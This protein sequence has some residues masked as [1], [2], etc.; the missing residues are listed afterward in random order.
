M[1]IIENSDITNVIK[2][3]EQPVLYVC[4]T[5]TNEMESDCEETLQNIESTTENLIQ[6]VTKASHKLI[7]L[8]IE[9]EIEEECVVNDILGSNDM[10]KLD[11]EQSDI[12]NEDNDD[13]GW[14]TPGKF[15]FII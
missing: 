9:N 14:I 5:S 13:D 11:I 1:Q 12:E 6:K 2:Q 7:N 15:I 8:K 10:T 3:D 4:N